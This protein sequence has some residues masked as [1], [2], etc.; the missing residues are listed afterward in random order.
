MNNPVR[1]FRFG[2]RSLLIAVAIIAILAAIYRIPGDG[3]RL[4]ALALFG[5][6][7]GVGLVF[8][9]AIRLVEIFGARE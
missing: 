6:M 8:V 4:E 2:L 5:N 7:V 1:R 9:A 3:D